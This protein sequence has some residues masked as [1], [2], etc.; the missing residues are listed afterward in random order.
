VTAFFLPIPGIIF[1]HPS[2][3]RAGAPGQVRPSPSF[4]WSWHLFTVISVLVI[5]IVAAASTPPRV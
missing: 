1:G 2:N 3:H 5:I 4:L